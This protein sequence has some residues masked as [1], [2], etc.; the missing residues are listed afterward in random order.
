MKRILLVVMFLMGAYCGFAQDAAEMINNANEALKSKDY[1]KAFELYDKAMKNLGDVQVDAA[2]NYNIGYAAFQIEKYDEA[3]AYLDK[4][5]AA[6]ANVAS[7]WEF[8]G[9]SYAKMEKY[10]EAID[11]YKKSIEAGAENKGSIYYNAGIVAYKGG[12]YEKATELFGKAVGENYNGDTAIFYKAV[13]LKKLDKDDEYKQTL[14]EGVQKFPDNEK[15]KSALANVYVSEGNELYKKGVAIINAANEKV[16]AGTLKTT[17]AEYNTEIDKSKV[18]FKDALEVLQKA[19]AADASNANAKKLIEA[20][21]S[22][23]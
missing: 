22:V 17:D 2:I 13:S 8:K 3:I 18:Q 4:A 11:A 15:L 20:C 9:N 19:I 14:V 7:A 6:N 1:A 5:I 16:K 10:N 12:M 23:L 21:K